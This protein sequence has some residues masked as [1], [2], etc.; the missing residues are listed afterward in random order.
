MAGPQG[1]VDFHCHHVPARF[2]LTTVANAPP[3]QKARWAV[4]NKVVADEGALLADIEAG[5]IQVRVIN[6]P[7]AHI[8]DAEGNVPH[9]TIMAINDELAR[10]VGRHKGR[11]I[12]LATVDGYDG[13]K[14]A[15]ELER[16][17]TQL[18]LKGVFLECARGSRLIDC[19]EA[20]PTLETAAR[21]GVPAFVHPVNPQPMTSQM[22]PYGRIGTLLARGSINSASLIALIESGAFKAMPGLK[23]VVTALAMGGLA[24]AAGFSHMSKLAGGTR[25][26]M[27]RHVFIETMGFHP[28]LIRTSVDL[29]GVGNVLVGSDWP[30]VSDGPIRSTVT[31][32]LAEAGLSAAEQAQVAAGN[33]L[34]LLGVER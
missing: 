21:L 14:S 6:T 8:C 31:A 33:A 7:T 25:D 19:P 11:I 32:A 12:A 28:A 24:M 26:V 3:T 15:R 9:A 22:E 17:V 1:I 2:E 5:D 16:A 13:D 23:V 29:L 18:G 10:I 4:T 27:R 20:R 30:I 34:R